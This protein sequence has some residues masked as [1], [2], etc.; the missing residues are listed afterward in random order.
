MMKTCRVPTA[1]RAV[2]A[3]AL[4][5]VSTVG[6]PASAFAASNHKAAPKAAVSSDAY[7][8]QLLHE[9]NVRR[10]RVGT[11]PVVYITADANAAVG[12]YLADLTP[13]ME[14]LNA[15]FHGQNNPV[16]PGWDYVAAS[17]LGGEARGEVLACP[18]DNGYWTTSRIADGWW[19]SPVHFESLYADA[20]V[21]AVACGTYGPQ[22]G[23]E[24][25]ETI[26]C[27]TYHI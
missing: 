23:G 17:G 12:E 13:R 25:F 15:C 16:A 27:V 11:P 20:Q 8:N 3:A 19:G 6:A 2:A 26:A 21:N 18:D 7:L 5:A 10:E 9:I 1:V 14:S 22:R 4:L 24:A